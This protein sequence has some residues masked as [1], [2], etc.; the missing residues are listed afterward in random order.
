MAYQ[1]P[2]VMNDA[3]GC[4]QKPNPISETK[5]ASILKGAYAHVPR[6]I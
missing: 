4:G 3:K 1:W 2:S 6:T 5:G